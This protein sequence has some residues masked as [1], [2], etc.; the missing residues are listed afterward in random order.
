SEMLLGT[1]TH[2]RERMLEELGL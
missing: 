2:H 1:P